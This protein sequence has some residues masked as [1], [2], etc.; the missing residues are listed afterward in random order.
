[1]RLLSPGD[2]NRCHHSCGMSRPCAKRCGRPVGAS[3]ADVYGR[4]GSR[5]YRPVS[6]G[7][8]VRKSGPTAMQPG[9]SAAV[10]SA[11]PSAAIRHV[12]LLNMTD[13]LGAADRL[14]AV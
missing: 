8:G 1:M 13:L 7:A 9:S 6:G 11:A 14:L 10:A 5:V 12:D 4:S 3:V 2:L